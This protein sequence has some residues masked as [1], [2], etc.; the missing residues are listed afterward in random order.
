MSQ[1]AKITADLFVTCVVDQLYPN[2][3][4]SVVK[5]LRKLG[6]T[7][8]FPEEQTCCGQPVYNTGFSQQ[9][10]TLAMRVLDQFRDTEYVVVPSGSCAATIRVFYLELFADDPELLAQAKALSAKTYEFSEFLVNVLK[11]E[12]AADCGATHQGSAAYHPS[13]HLLRELGVRSG[14]QKLLASVPGLEQKELEGSEIC[15]GFGGT[16]SVKFPH[17]SEGM[18]T[19]KIANVQASGADTLVSCDMSC[20]MN[21]SG[22]LNRQG[23]DIKV[24]HLAQIL[25]AESD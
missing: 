17:I 22:A 20:L 24:R 21:I 7:I 25:D 3:G 15:C 19:D 11:V 23:S 2:V 18:V 1:Q 16:F 14:P 5:V 9:A 13:C 10:R 6:V 8:G 4:I 12:N